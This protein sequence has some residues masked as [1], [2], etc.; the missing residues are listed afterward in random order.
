M[1]DGGTGRYFLA[2]LLY[3]FFPDFSSLLFSRHGGEGAVWLFGQ[4]GNSKEEAAQA[5]C[6]APFRNCQPH[7]RE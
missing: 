5:R 7:K 4:A 2:A 6:A 3:Y 1:A